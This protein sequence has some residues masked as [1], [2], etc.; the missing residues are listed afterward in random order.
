MKVTSIG[1]YSSNDVQVA[2]LSFRDPGSLNPYVARNIIGLD[3]DEIVP[4][5]YGLSR[6]YDGKY[7]DL[8]I[9]S[10]EIVLSIM[11]N[12]EYGE[13]DKSY[14][15]L[16]D[17][18][19]KSVAASRT[20][21]MGLRFYEGFDEVARISG[22]ITKLE[23]PHF[24]DLPEIQLTLYCEDPMLRGPNQISLHGRS[25][26]DNSFFTVRDSTAPHGFQCKLTFT[27]DVP[28]FYIQDP[29]LDWQFMVEPT[30]N[31]L[32]NDELYLSSESGN[33]ELRLVRSNVH[34]YLV[35]RI[36]P[37]SSVWP[38]FFPG[39]NK[40][41]HTPQIT[42]NYIKYYPTYWGV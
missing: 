40:F 33:K 27:A 41:V 3:A 14:S 7:F 9:P 32:T 39:D 28:T 11:L 38:I 17:D 42:W 23:Y 35:D 6:N 8:S 1:L 4:R 29:E 24:T 37:E 16:R 10:R 19:Y 5:F 22:F 31:F 12:P 2:L 30:T 34:S 21:V 15:D 13:Y 25:G 26:S 18:I 36:K 20:G